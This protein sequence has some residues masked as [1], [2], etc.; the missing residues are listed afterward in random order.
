MTPIPQ[1]EKN[2][3]CGVHQKRYPV[4]G[5]RLGEWVVFASDYFEHMYESAVKLIKKGKAYVSD[6]S[7]E[8]IREYRVH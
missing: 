4:A 5:S 1:K 2:G 3:I 7:A 8:K 6:L